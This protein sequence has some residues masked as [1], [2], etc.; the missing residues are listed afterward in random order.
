MNEEILKITADVVAAYVGNNSL[1][2]DE[3]P[4]V[5]DTVYGSLNAKNSESAAVEKTVTL[6]PAVPIKKSITPDHLVCLEDGRELKMLKRHL[7][8]A[9]K[10]TPDQYRDKWGLPAN[11]PM[12]SPNYSKVRSEQAK[13]M[14]LGTR[15]RRKK[16]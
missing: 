6:T 2:I 7:W 5:I 9:Y 14:K 3:L 10:L 4:K 12:V 16:L 15:K 8:T 1:S 11:Y 13:A